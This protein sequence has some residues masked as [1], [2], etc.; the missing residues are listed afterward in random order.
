MEQKQYICKCKGC[1][2]RIQDP[3]DKPIYISQ[4]D[5]YWCSQKCLNYHDPVRREVQ[6]VNNW[7]D[8]GGV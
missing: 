5:E 3:A 6:E 8:R 1:G 7:L 4:L 2:R